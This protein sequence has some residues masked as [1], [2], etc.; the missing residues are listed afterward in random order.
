MAGQQHGG[1]AISLND[2]SCR[3][4][5]DGGVCDVVLEIPSGS[6]LAIVGASG[7]GKSTLLRLIAGLESGDEGSLLIDGQMANQDGR[8]MM[9]PDLRKVG[10]VFQDF[11]LFP[12]M[13][14]LDN[15]AFAAHRQPRQVQRQRAEELMD[16]VGLG[17]RLHAK[18]S[19]LSGGEQ[20]RVALARA[21][22][23][24]PKI[25][26]L[27]EPYSS[28]DARLRDDLA[29]MTRNI[30]R[31]LG[32]TAILVSHDGDE[33]LRF[34]DRV[35]FMKSGRLLFDGAMAD[36]KE[37]SV[38]P[39]LLQLLFPLTGVTLDHHGGATMATPWGQVLCLPDD[40]QGP[41]S[42]QLF[43]IPG[44]AMV[45]EHDSGLLLVRD[46]HDLGLTREMLLALPDG[47]ELRLQDV[48]SL[49]KAGTRVSLS[50]DPE[51][52]F[53]FRSST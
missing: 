36:L 12:H 9:A 44:A 49:A 8:I 24:D 22:A 42:V 5:G 19:Q 38:P 46:N 10:M 16:R 13:S 11:A 47:R 53:L 40:L 30:V 45:E 23:G 2:I 27:D 15:V 21:L 14:A 33:A 39:D 52:L 50:L 31:E 48:R 34:A 37:R 32:I 6:Q 35:A 29:S 17:H 1:S 26:L 18:P 20:Q 4:G 7:S 28:L 43:T 3:F 41:G 51:R 25:L